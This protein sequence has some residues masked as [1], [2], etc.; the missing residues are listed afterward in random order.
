MERAGVCGSNLGHLE[1]L[2][3]LGR[4]PLSGGGMLNRFALQ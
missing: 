3:E 1:R 4:P 2:A